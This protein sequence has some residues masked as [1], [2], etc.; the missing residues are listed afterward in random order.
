MTGDQYEAVLGALGD[1]LAAHGDLRCQDLAL[2]NLGTVRD[3]YFAL[4][5]ALYERRGLLDTA[6][7]R[8]GE[9]AD[10]YGAWNSAEERIAELEADLANANL[11][12]P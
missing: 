11:Y 6:D 7:D 4:D 2:L 5:E 10:L 12:A 9:Y 1:A 8:C 3:A